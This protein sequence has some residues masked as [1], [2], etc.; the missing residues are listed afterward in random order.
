[1]LG[2]WHRGAVTLGHPSAQPAAPPS[3]SPPA[4][5]SLGVLEIPFPFLCLRELPAKAA[6]RGCSGCLRQESERRKCQD[7]KG[8]SFHPFVSVRCN[9]NFHSNY[10]MCFSHKAPAPFSTCR[11]HRAQAVQRKG[12]PAPTSE[13]G[14]RSDG[15]KRTEEKKVLIP[16]N[17][18][19]LDTGIFILPL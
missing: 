18:P 14:H 4:L 16:F 5:P 9:M 7:V 6:A 11:S 1:M 3:P 19:S 12:N 17:F 2:R 10:W 15:D 8:A 13:K